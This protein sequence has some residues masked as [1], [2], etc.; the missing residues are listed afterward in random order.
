MLTSIRPN[1][2]AAL[3]ERSRIVPIAL[4]VQLR[5]LG[6]TWVV[7]TVREVM[8]EVDTFAIADIA[9]VVFTPGDGNGLAA[10]VE[11]CDCSVGVGVW[12]CP[13]SRL[14]LWLHVRRMERL[15]R[16]SGYNACPGR[17]TVPPP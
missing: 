11:S 16:V 13:R 9:F 8:P 15:M 14:G 2:P 17:G 7:V 1:A 10:E 12:L 4:F 5:R 3:T 6:I